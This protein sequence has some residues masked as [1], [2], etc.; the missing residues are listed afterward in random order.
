MKTLTRFANSSRLTVGVNEMLATPAFAEKPNR[1]LS[2]QPAT[3][4][5]GLPSTDVIVDGRVIGADPDP[6]IRSQLL[7]ESESL[8]GD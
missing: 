6:Q 3:E 7:R 8:Q 1:H 5:Q 4:F 2:P